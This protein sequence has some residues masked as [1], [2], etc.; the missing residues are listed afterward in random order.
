MNNSLWL[1]TAYTRDSYPALDKDI[2]CDV[3][4]IGGGLSGIANAY[5]LA[6]EGLDVVLLEKDEILSGAT[7]NST[8]KLTL[9]H[10]LVYAN[11][12]K[13]FGRDNAKTYF[14]A[15]RE[16]VLFGK[17]FAIGDELWDANSILF[18][19]S[20]FGTKLLQDEKRAYDEI[21]IAAVLGRDSELPLKTEATLTIK[22]EAQIHPVRFGQHLAQLSVKAGARI[23]E[24]TQ[25]RLMDLKK[26]ILNTNSNNEIQFNKLILCTHYPIAAL[27]G[28]QILKLTVGRSYVVS[29]SANMPLQGQ[30]ISVDS[31]KRSVRTAFID[32]QAHFL[33]S[34]EGHPANVEKETRIHYRTLDSELKYVYHLDPLQYKWS[35]QDPST[36]DL[37]PYA[38]P[39][40]KSMP[41][42]YLNTGFRKWGLSNSLACA[43]IISDQ[44]I[45]RDNKAS[46]LYAPDRTGFGSFLVQAL[47]NTGLVL[48]E[49]TGGY[50][51]RTG[52]P[53]CTHMG[54]RTKWNEADETWDCP[55]HGSRFRKDGSILEGPAT[56]PLDLG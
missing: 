53:I 48:K 23:F 17:G 30:Y 33:L 4:I 37:I 54:C 25:I 10:D 46:S 11:L 45:G 26:R 9:Q 3:C 27:Q 29:T 31:P 20:K 42:V 24:K 44:I 16:A 49:F 19:Q 41:Y 18:S 5:F 6:K 21:G 34:G 15:N 56:K 13:Q 36:P 7:G 47:K 32:G 51:R 52:T 50:I 12:I 8:G 55:C 40:S 2:S 22:D 14:D 35:A 39:I 38:G 43:R 28:L 1:K